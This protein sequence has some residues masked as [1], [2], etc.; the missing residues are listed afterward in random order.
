VAVINGYLKSFDHKNLYWYYWPAN[1]PKG[2]IYLVHG[3]GEH[4]GRY[5]H[6]AHY[7]ND[8]GFSCFG[9]DQRG[10]GRSEGKRGHTPSYEALLK[11]IDLFIRE[12]QKLNGNLIPFLYGHSFG[13]NLVLNYPL[14]RRTNFRGVIATSPWLEL[15]TPPS[16]SQEL[17][18]HIACV[19]SPS[20]TLKT[21]LNA[22]G[23]AKE[24]TVASNY[25]GDEYVHG[26]ITVNMYTEIKRAAHF[27][28]ANAS[29]FPLPLL[30]VHGDADPITSFAASKKFANK[31]PHCTFKVWEG[32]YHETHNEANW[33]D[34]LDF[35]LEWML[36]LLNH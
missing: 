16:K 29:R 2:A 23:L 13:G 10:H 12:G 25:T 26:L 3:M 28:S 30:L 22:E 11:D 4:A 9:F 18:A 20:L 1:N 32:L 35:N 31:A 6:V 21:G 19:F 8:K 27:A 17:V 5:E 34:V 15:A 14:R 24:K 36:K 7:F 33:M